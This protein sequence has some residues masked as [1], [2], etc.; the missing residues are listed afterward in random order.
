MACSGGNKFINVR[1]FIIFRSTEGLNSF[2][3]NNLANFSD[4]KNVSGLSIFWERAKKIKIKSRPC[5]V[6]RRPRTGQRFLKVHLKLAYLHLDFTAYSVAIGNDSET[7]RIYEPVAMLQTPKIP[8]VTESLWPNMIT[9][10]VI[11]SRAKGPYYFFEKRVCSKVAF[12]FSAKWSSAGD[13][14]SLD[15]TIWKWIQCA[16]GKFLVPYYRWTYDWNRRTYHNCLSLWLLWNRQR[17]QIL[18]YFSK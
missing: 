8:L 17:A 2:K 11:K 16:F 6:L 10:H 15:S 18:P 14:R 7:V 13:N 5:C 9:P 4:G 3:K 12:F 1:T